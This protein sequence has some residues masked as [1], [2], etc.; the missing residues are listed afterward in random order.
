M[1]WIRLAPSIRAHSSISRGIVLK[2]RRV[3]EPDGLDHVAERDEEQ[4][5]RHQVRD[6]D[7]RP[8][9]CRP[10]ELQPRQGVAGEQP[11]EERDRR[12]H[13]RDEQGIPGPAGEHGQ[14]EQV[15]EMLAASR[16]APAYA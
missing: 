4:G 9:R 1:A 5:G 15:L 13:R 2:P 11:A 3:S 6:E 7:Q 8:E 14:L 12:R 16:G 10:A